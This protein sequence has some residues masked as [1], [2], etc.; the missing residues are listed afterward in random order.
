MRTTRKLAAAVAIAALAA[1]TAAFAAPADMHSPATD[2]TQDLRGPDARGAVPQQPKQD[3]RAPDARPVVVVHSEPRVP[4]AAPVA[5]VGGSG[6]GLDWT[7]I[8]LGI[9]GSLLAVCAIGA[10]AGR[11]SRRPERVRV[12]A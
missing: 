6:D 5:D 10:L 3:L 8:G 1:P 11:R 2:V 12:A 7:T 9:A 4:S